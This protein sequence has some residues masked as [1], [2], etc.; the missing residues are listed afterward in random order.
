MQ[1]NSTTP[2]DPMR[3][4]VASVERWKARLLALAVVAAN[5]TDDASRR[6]AMNRYEIHLEE[7]QWI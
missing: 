2:T 4:Y 6:R 1:P 5:C 7:L 3:T